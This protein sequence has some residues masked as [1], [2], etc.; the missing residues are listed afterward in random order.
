MI[1]AVCLR[2]HK[3]RPRRRALTGGRSVVRHFHSSLVESSFVVSAEHEI[4]IEKAAASIMSVQRGSVHIFLWV[5][6]DQNSNTN[7]ERERC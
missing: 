5:G 7:I 1:F 3:Q 2:P 6:R 4:S